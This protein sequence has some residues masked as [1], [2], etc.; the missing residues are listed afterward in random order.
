MQCE[1]CKKKIGLNEGI[2]F[3]GNMYHRKCL[4]KVNPFWMS[5]KKEKKIVKI[6]A[7]QEI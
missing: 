4:N 3:V 2:F 5:P 7:Y 6:E 1:E